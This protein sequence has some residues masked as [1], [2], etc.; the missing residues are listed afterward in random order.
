MSDINKIKAATT[1]AVTAMLGACSTAGISD[2]MASPE[3]SP[4]E[5]PASVNGP[6]PVSMPQPAPITQDYAQNSLWRTGARSFFDDQR[7]GDIGDILTVNIEIS[8]QA[9]VNN[10]TSRSRTGNTSA[11]INAMFGL[12]EL[13]DRNI[14]GGIGLSPGADFGSSSSSN[15][16]GTVNRAETIDLTIA[17]VIT[18]KLPNGNLVIAGSQEVKVNN[19]VRELVVGGIIR[20]QDISA[21]NTISHEQIAQARISYGGR[22]DLSNLQRASTAA[23]AVD[24]IN[25]F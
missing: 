23:R 3:L 14:P 16:T 10:T 6:Y 9:Q 4:I 5:N 24:A 11:E 25:P 21:T 13:I 20:P 18:Q 22:G 2:K 15:G 19:E 1:F 7:A 12:N 8:D 17:A